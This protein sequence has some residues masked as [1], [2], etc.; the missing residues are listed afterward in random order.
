MHQQAGTAYYFEGEQPLEE[1]GTSCFLRDGHTVFHTY[2]TY[3]RGAEM[4]GGSYYWLDLTALGRQEA[5]E[6]PQGRAESA[7]GATPDLSA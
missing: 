3:G 2:S 5:W 1:P 4:M 7:R 6:E